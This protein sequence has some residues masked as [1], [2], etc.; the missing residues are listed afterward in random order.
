M[1]SNSAKCSTVKKTGI[2]G[3]GY[4]LKLDIDLCTKIKVRV[5]LLFTCPCQQKYVLY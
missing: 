4:L 2:W 3:V 1:L 5:Q